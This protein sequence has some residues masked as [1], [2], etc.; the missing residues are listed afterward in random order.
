MTLLS[1]PWPA[2]HLPTDGD[3]QRFA[4]ALEGLCP[5]P[6]ETLL[7]ALAQVDPQTVSSWLE[8]G[9]LREWVKQ[10]LHILAEKGERGE[11]LATSL[12]T[13]TPTLL[14]TLTAGE[15]GEWVRLGLD[16]EA[17]DRPGVFSVLPDSFAALPESERLSLY[18]LARAAAYRSA[19]LAQTFPAGVA[20]LF[21]TL[22]RA[23]DE[24]GEEGVKAW[25]VAGEEIARRNPQAGEAFFAL[26]SRTS[27]LTLRHT[28][29]AVSLSDVQG[30]LLKYLHMLCGAAVSLTE[31][32]SLS[33]PPPLAEADGD[34][35][36]RPA[37]VRH[38]RPFPAS[39]LALFA[40]CC[41]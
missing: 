37:R 27:L 28:S 32:D 39:S 30:L 23:Y 15:I 10:G 29:P 3:Q 12:F 40:R 33:F 8:M 14:P 22:T 6:R 34:T 41:A 2:R 25:I 21:R 11:L 19:Q 5:V 38:L 9:T 24:V 26:E 7:R 20:R 18:R 36:P 16:I 13:A 31:T 1:H 17:A 35:L 4:A